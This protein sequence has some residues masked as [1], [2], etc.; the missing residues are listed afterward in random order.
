MLYKI[1]AKKELD[2]IDHLSVNFEVENTIKKPEIN[3]RGM[4]QINKNSYHSHHDLFF[5]IIGDF[6]MVWGY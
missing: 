5:L 2:F 4:G 6:M 3:G 1:Y